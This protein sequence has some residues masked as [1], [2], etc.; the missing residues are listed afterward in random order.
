MIA[1]SGH[2]PPLVTARDTQ[3]HNPP[4]QAIDSNL[5]TRWSAEGEGAWIQADL[6]A[7]NDLC[8]VQIA[9]FR[10][11]ERRARFR[12]QVSANGTR[13]RE[14]LEARASGLTS[15]P[16]NYDIP[17][18][19]ARFV[20][21]VVDGNSDN[22]WASITEISISRCRPLLVAGATASSFEPGNG[23]ANAIDGSD[24]TRWE[25]RGNDEWLQLDL[26]NWRTASSVAIAWHQGDRRRYRFLVETSGD[27]IHFDE[28]FEGR[29]S[30]QTTAAERYDFGNR[31]TRYLRVTVLSNDPGITEMV[32]IGHD[33]CVV[34]PIPPRPGRSD[35]DEDDC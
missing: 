8:A 27:G 21:I 11:E 25:A 7:V 28:I 14:V 3:P 1:C 24:A 33:D 10:G 12:I 2:T 18:S 5:S 19:T 4:G 17:E 23:P 16:E 30:G 6:G 35:K 20:R 26:G 32:P 22:D 9:W 13:F 29:S 31:A 15:A 34:P